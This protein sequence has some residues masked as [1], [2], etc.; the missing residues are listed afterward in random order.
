MKPYITTI[1]D[2][3]CNASAIVAL[4]KTHLDKF[5][6]RTGHDSHEGF[7]PHV[8]SRFSTLKD[9]DMSP[10]L[11]D[12][13]FEES[14][15]DSFL[16]DSYS[17]IQIQKYEPGEFIVPHEDAYGIA[18]LHLV[19]LTEGKYDSLIIE[20]G[21]GGLIRIPDR[22]GQYVDFSGELAHWVD[23][24]IEQRFTLVIGE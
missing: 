9:V 7:I 15:F 13:I 11:I 18:K 16:Q 19:T 21:K 4:A 23:P 3:I 22:A 5:K 14:Q 12:L 24:V 8:K 17:F 20:D 10:Y 6:P 1:P 2:Y